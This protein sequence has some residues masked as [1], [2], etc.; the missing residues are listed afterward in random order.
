MTPEKKCYILLSVIKMFEQQKN[1]KEIYSITLIRP[2][3]S[4]KKKIFNKYVPR[5][6]L[7]Y[8]LS[9]EVITHFNNKTAQIV[10]GVV[11]IIPKC[12]NADYYIERTNVGDCIDIF[13]DTEKPFIDELLC[14]NFSSDKEMKKLFESVYR[15]WI[16]KTDGYYYKAMSLVYEILYKMILKSNKNMPSY[17]YKKIEKGIDY[18]KNHLYSNDIDYYIPSEICGISYTY[19][20]KL[21]IEK[22]RYSAG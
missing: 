5:Y 13:F 2:N 20:K 14:L 8:K 12:D 16:T 17:K 15:L 9:G 7:I 10:P 4:E 11:Y 1:I 18:L 6:Q 3:K 21:F 22:I 19:F